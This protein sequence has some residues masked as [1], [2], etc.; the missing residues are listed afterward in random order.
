MVGALD[1][2]LGRPI[3]ISRR[4]VAGQPQ[5]KDGL[6]PAWSQRTELNRLRRGY[7]PRALPEVAAWMNWHVDKELNPACSDLESKP[8]PDVDVQRKG[9]GRLSA[10]PARRRADKH[11]NPWERPSLVPP[12]GL[13]PSPT[14]FVASRPVCGTVAAEKTRTSFGVDDA[15]TRRSEQWARHGL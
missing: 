12:E 11:L 4:P 14:T 15:L 8:V 10:R 2:N 9:R 5:V 13:A 3:T 1:S 7:E 6:R